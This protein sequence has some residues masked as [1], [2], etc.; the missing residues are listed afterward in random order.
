M[1]YSLLI[2]MFS[3]T[4]CGEEKAPQTTVQDTPPPPTTYSKSINLY[5]AR[6]FELDKELINKF[7]KEYGVK[8][9]VVLDNADNIIRRIKDEADKPQADVVLLPGLED[10]YQLKEAHLLYPFSDPLID[11]KTHSRNRDKDNMWTS[12]SKRA[13]GVG[14]AHKRVPYDA[15]ATYD[16]LIAPKFRKK[17]VISS[18]QNKSNQFFIASMLVTE[19]EAKTKKWIKGIMSNLAIP[20]VAS[21][22]EAV[23]AV[24][25]GKADLSIINTSALIQYQH[26]G[27]PEDFDIGS[28]VGIK[29]PV[30]TKNGTYYNLTP[31]GIVKGTKD[32]QNAL[33]L[34]IFLTGKEQQPIFCQ[35]LHEYPVNGFAEIDDFL[36]GIGG[37]NEVAMDFDEVFK[38]IPRAKAIMKEYHWE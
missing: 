29:Y 19:G 24:G 4:A 3:I 8:V 27:Q 26:S 37:F 15:F 18:A 17:I 20:P 35:T 11:N 14:G 32:F 9:N 10:I 25:Q 30:N 36:I 12:L 5:T 38:S 1:R 2:L 16:D 6:Y 21:D 13:I 28:N 33:N 23:K 22:I 31:I 7:Q 34:I